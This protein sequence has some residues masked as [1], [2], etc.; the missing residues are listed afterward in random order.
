MYD[1][2][3]RQFCLNALYNY[4]LRSIFSEKTQ[5]RSSWGI[6]RSCRWRG[7]WVVWRIWETTSR[8]RPRVAWWSLSLSSVSTRISAPWSPC[9]PARRISGW[10][11]ELTLVVPESNLSGYRNVC[12]GQTLDAIFFGTNYKGLCFGLPD[13]SLPSNALARQQPSSNLLSAAAGIN[14]LRCVYFFR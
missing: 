5:R 11:W 14:F 8:L 9:R 4:I 12:G 3:L 13:L 2:C 10:R 7:G 6:R 1:F